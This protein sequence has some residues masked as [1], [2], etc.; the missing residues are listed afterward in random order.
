[1]DNPKVPKNLIHTTSLSYCAPQQ[2][3]RKSCSYKQTSWPV[4]IYP[5]KKQKISLRIKAGRG[6]RHN[7][8]SSKY[9]ES[10][11]LHKSAKRFTNMN[12]Y[13]PEYHNSTIFLDYRYYRHL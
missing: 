7:N 3:L 4:K 5:I 12:T 9:Q 11:L 6:R 10:K 2:A 8:P 1:M 13:L